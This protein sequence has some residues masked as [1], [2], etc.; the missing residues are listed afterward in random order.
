MEYFLNVQLAHH[1][2]TAHSYMCNKML[3]LFYFIHTVLIHQ[4]SHEC[5]NYLIGF[6]LFLPYIIRDFDRITNTQQ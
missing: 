3:V 1:Y 5:F 2:P 6:S 4:C